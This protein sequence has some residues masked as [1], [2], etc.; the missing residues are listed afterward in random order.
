MPLRRRQL[1]RLAGAAALAAPTRRFAYADDYPTRPVRIIE[2]LGGG[3]T[4]NLVARLIGQW[5]SEHLNQPFV[6]ESRTGAG[7]NIATQAVVGAAPDGYTLLTIVTTNAINATLYEKLDFD[8][9]RDITP[10]AGVVRLPMVL[11]VNPA[12]PAATLG[13]FI[14]Y[15]KANPGK[16]NIASPGIGTPMHVGIELLKLMAGVDLVHIAYRGPAAVWPDLFSGQVQAFIITVST[17]IGFI[18][19][20][21]V[22]PLAVTV[23]KR[24]DVLPEIPPI[25]ETLPG[26][27]ASAW[28]GIGAPTGTP[29]AII[30][31][32]ST[33]I[34]VGLA[35]P[36]LKARITDLGGDTEPM[37]SAQFKNFIA[38]ETKKWAK[39]VKFSGAKVN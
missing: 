22:R 19:A 11:M 12:F 37:P 31:E 24:T 4:P 38:D 16:V 28:N 17:A 13:E 25:A 10:I 15:A 7:G 14:A 2:G 20:G 39:V 1:L 5:L 32:L 18:R 3:S 36:Q 30:D 35:D 23:A 6:V 26:F 29:A 27:E 33:N 8:F 21:K 9:I 34:V